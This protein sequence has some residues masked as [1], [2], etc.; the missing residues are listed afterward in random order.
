MSVRWEHK[1]FSKENNAQG[2]CLF[3][4]GAGNFTV[5]STIY[6]NEIKN[7]SSSMTV[8]MKPNVTMWMRSLI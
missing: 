7:F 6:V 8:W 5:N 1:P 4:A 3:L 2:L